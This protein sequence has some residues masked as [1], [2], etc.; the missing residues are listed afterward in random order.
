MISKKEYLKA[1]N[2]VREFE[3]QEIEKYNLKGVKIGDKIK[4]LKEPN[5]K[6][7]QLT[8]NKIYS[9]SGWVD[10]SIILMIRDNHG[11]NRKV[12]R[13]NRKKRWVKVK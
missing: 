5:T 10:H 11:E 12:Y 2:I 9:I 1:L 3:A 7:G 13:K 8:K 4:L 6:N